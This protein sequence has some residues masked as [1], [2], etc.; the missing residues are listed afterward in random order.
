MGVNSLTGIE[1][2]WLKKDMLIYDNIELIIHDLS[3]PLPDLKKYD[4]AISLEVA[5]HLNEK[6]AKGIIKDLCNLSN[7]VLFSAGVTGL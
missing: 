3:N 1:G 2:S 5:E 4:L 6:R 7:V